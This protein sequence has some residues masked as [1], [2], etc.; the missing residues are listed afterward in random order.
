M[1]PNSA[2]RPACP[3]GSPGGPPC[4]RQSGVLSRHI[5]STSPSLTRSSQPGGQTLVAFQ[6]SHATTISPTTA[7][8]NR[9]N[10]RVR[11]PDCDEHT[12]LV[13]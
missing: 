10:Y 9:E 5:A 11:I 12:L 4:I 13:C 6:F 7:T 8:G 3:A 2:R 1:C